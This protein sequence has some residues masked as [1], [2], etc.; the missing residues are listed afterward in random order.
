VELNRTSNL[1]SGSNG[2]ASSIGGPSLSTMND[3]RY[4]TDLSIHRRRG[5]EH[6]HTTRSSFFELLH[7]Y[8]PRLVSITWLGYAWTNHAS[9]STRPHQFSP[10]LHYSETAPSDSSIFIKVWGFNILTVT[11]S[12]LLLAIC[13]FHRSDHHFSSN[14]LQYLL[15]SGTNPLTHKPRKLMEGR[16]LL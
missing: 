1:I 11:F 3:P 6:I 7:R 5:S 12:T 15:S 2:I 16:V 9:R 14:L 10:Q 4:W 13:R 8:R